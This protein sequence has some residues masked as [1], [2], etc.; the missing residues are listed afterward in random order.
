MVCHDPETRLHYD[1]TA[2]DET[3]LE[4]SGIHIA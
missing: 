4:I 2:Y 1:E 3:L